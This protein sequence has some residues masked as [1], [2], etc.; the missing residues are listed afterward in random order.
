M[1]HCYMDMVTETMYR[2]AL[3][4]YKFWYPTLLRGNFPLNGPKF[5]E[6]QSLSSDCGGTIIETSFS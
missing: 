2:A 6:E 3:V 5:G 1:T 4:P